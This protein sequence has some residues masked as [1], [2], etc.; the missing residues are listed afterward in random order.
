MK[1]QKTRVVSLRQLKWTTIIAPLAFLA[2][3]DYV[4]RAVHVA[5]LQEWPGEVLGHNH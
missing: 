3:V 5:F 1:I 4:R 2:L